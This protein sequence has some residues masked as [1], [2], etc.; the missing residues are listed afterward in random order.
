MNIKA[1]DRDLE[2]YLSGPKPEYEFRGQEMIGRM[3]DE[4]TIAFYYKDPILV[5][6]NGERNIKRPD[7]TLPVYN[8]AVIVYIPIADESVKHDYKV[9]KENDIAALFIKD[10]NLA[11]PD[12]KQKLYDKLEETYHQPH[13]FSSDKYKPL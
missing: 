1:T 7:F 5:W 2:Y 3:L 8:N 6:E 12:W 9:Y 4:Y 11:D 13:N 10:S